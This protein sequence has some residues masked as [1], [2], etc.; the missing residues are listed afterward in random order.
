MGYT[1]ENEQ[2]RYQREWIQKRKRRYFSDKECVVCGATELAGA[3][4]E[5][6]WP[7]GAG[8]TRHRFWSLRWAVVVE[9]ADEAEPVCEECTPAYDSVK[10]DKRLGVAA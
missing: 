9:R 10:R 6:R 4:L 7:E 8:G 3:R 5:L 2:R 1:D